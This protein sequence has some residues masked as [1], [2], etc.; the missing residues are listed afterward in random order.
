MKA[1]CCIT[2]A[3]EIL[4]RV[5]ISLFPGRPATVIVTLH[6]LCGAAYFQLAQK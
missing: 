2:I 1:S 6:W 4:P 5:G 3:W